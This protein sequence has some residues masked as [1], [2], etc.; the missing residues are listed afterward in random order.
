MPTF[1]QQEH[2]TRMQH[3]SSHHNA[4]SCLCSHGQ[5]ITQ[6]IHP[7]C[8]IQSQTYPHHDRSNSSPCALIL[9]IPHRKSSIHIVWQKAEVCLCFGKAHIFQDLCHL[10]SWGHSRHNPRGNYSQWPIL[11]RQYCKCVQ[12][13][14]CGTLWQPFRPP[15]AQY[16]SSVSFLVRHSIKPA[17]GSP[18][19]YTALVFSE[20]FW[21]Q[22][23]LL[24]HEVHS[25]SGFHHCNSI[26]RDSDNLGICTG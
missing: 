16:T 5:C 17:L 3:W 8:T 19:T 1:C 20:Y 4:C 9:Y 7:S 15:C 2:G 18:R 6:V 26:L 22:P 24:K 12:V 11:F 21:Q 13:F 14:W 25:T 23:F 10:C